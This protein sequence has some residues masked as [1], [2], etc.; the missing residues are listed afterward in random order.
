MFL[1]LRLLALAG[2]ARPAR[3][4][5]V[6]FLF[7]LS[8]FGA[9]S[10]LVC[11]SWLVVRHDSIAYRLSGDTS[12]FRVVS[13][14]FAGTDVV[15]P[16]TATSRVRFIRGPVVT[17]KRRGVGRQRVIARS[18]YLTQTEYLEET[19][20]RAE[21]R[22][23]AGR[24]GCSQP[25][26]A[27]VPAGAAV[28]QHWDVEPCE[29]RYKYIIVSHST[30]GEASA[31]SHCFQFLSFE[32]KTKNFCFGSDTLR[33]F[34]FFSSFFLWSLRLFGPLSLSVFNGSFDRVVIRCS[35]RSHG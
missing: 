24:R 16:Y 6:L 3:L 26:D 29:T 23:C 9:S 1:S 13:S 10:L 33:F 22:S 34:F 2:R 11:F 7:F 20:L 31:R 30:G 35:L 14:C 21:A 19:G 12:I 27:A 18:D 25:W 5:L 15:H 17:R 32:I 8:S 28:S 4:A